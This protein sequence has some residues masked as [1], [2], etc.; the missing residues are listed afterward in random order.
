MS[1]EKFVVKINNFNIISASNKIY[2]VYYL[3]IV[4]DLKGI[5]SKD[6]ENCFEELKISKYSNIPQYLKINSKKNKNKSAKFIFQNGLYHLE[7]NKKN[8]IDIL[9]NVPQIINPSDD[10]FPIEIF[11]NTRGYLESIA[12]QTAACYDNRLFDAC[13]VLTRKLLEILIIEAFEKHNIADKIKDKNDNFL[14][15]SDL[16]DIFRSELKW[17]VSRNAKDSLPRL[18][19]MGDLSAHNR[20][21]F[22]KKPDV[23]KL[24]DDL[25]IVIEELIH[26][27][28]YTN[29][30]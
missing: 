2:F 8:E 13:S 14:Y 5:R 19:K 18:K 27:I 25:R 12:L 30:K 29:W 3:T 26:I 4:D 11:K 17:N 20:R 9:L 28:D 22:S 24:K 15:L 1:L 23:D 21:Y 7:R 10:Y 16:I 6:I